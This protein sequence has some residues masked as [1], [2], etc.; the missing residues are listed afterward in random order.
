ME[1]V[2]K[3]GK[4]RAIGVSNFSIKKLEELLE[5]A[6]I[7]PHANQVELHP[8]LP[9]HDLVKW[10]QDKNILMEAYSPLGSQDSP[11]WVTSVASHAATDL[12]RHE[13]G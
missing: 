9:Q 6:D 8:Y 10:C 3:S 2:Y 13:S 1:A 12:T 4:A 5:T 7:T 11:L